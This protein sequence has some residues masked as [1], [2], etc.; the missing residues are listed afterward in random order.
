[1]TRLALIWHQHQPCYAD[2]RRG[3]AAMPWVRLHGVKDYW[4]MPALL[5]EFPGVKAHVN[6]VPGLILQIEAAAGGMPDPW[7]RLA[8]IPAEDLRAEDRQAILETFFMAQED[9]LVRANARYGELLAKARG[10]SRWRPEALATEDWRDLQVWHNLAWFHPLLREEMPLVKEL[11]E[12]QRGFTEGDK[13]AVLAAQREVLAGLVPAHRLMQDAG[14]IEVT[15][16]PYWHPILPLLC[17]MESARVAMANVVLPKAPA[18]DMEDDARAHLARAVALYR[19]R[20]GRDPRGLWP[21][22]GSVSPDMVPLVEEAGFRWMAT[23]EGVLEASLG[24]DFHRDGRGLYAPWLAG[25]KLAMVFRDHA[26]S[27]LVGFEYK[28]ARADEAADDLIAR[29]R[30]AGRASG[31]GALV[32]LALDGEN[33]WEHFPGLGVPFLRAFYRRLEDAKDIQTVLLGEELEKNPPRR[34]LERLWSGSWIHRNFQIWVGHPEDNAG[35]EQLGQAR[36]SLLAATK[37]A[38]RDPRQGPP[39]KSL[40]A[41]PREGI[42]AAW[43]SMFAAEGSDWFWWFGEEHF[44]PVAGIFDALFRSHLQNVYS[45]LGLPVPSGLLRPIKGT[46]APAPSWTQ[47]WA[48]LDVKIDGRR[49]DYYEWI[50]AGHYDAAKDTDVMDRSSAWIRGVYFGFDRRHLLI[51]VD[52]AGPAKDGLLTRC[53]N[54][55]FMN[56]DRQT[57]TVG[58]GGKATG[59]GATAAAGDI[60]EISIPLRELDVNPGES[61]EFFVEAAA[62]PASQRVPARMPISVKVPAEEDERVHWVV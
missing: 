30:A 12:K 2:L 54:I 45:A 20:F 23:D 3:E 4:G 13:D 9:N 33:A 38:G 32:T 35:W 48:L 7:L 1:V 41:I 6:L 62:G 24:S 28:R 22:E 26:V 53:V 27:D 21:S 37:A 11:F 42:D 19:D 5:R 36:A 57:V 34:R 47:P 39:P 59:C 40:A 10:A 17:R 16:T 55:I 14:Q 44:S 61:L 52:A 18:L 8:R 56:T 29:I 51:R 60:L 50:S 43:E 46:V 15:T 31:P 49:S 58:A 25:E